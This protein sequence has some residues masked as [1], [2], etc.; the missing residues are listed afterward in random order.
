LNWSARAQGRG[1]AERLFGWLEQAQCSGGSFGRAL[2]QVERRLDRN[3]LL[4][5]VSDWWDEVALAAALALCARQQVLAV[6]VLSP[7][8]LEPSFGANAALRLVDSESG[9]EVELTVDAGAL[10]SYRRAIADWRRDMRRDFLRAGARFATLG[11]DES[12]ERALLIDWH[13]SRIIA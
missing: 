4:I 10:D 12:I 1:G 13:R 9:Q 3:G 6:Q 5:V 7:D 2:R 8:E 11:T